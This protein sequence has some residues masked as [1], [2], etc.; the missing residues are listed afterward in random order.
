[1][2]DINSQKS[3]KL[4]VECA[5]FLFISVFVV[6]RA[7]QDL[8]LPLQFSLDPPNEEALEK[9]RK[10]ITTGFMDHVAR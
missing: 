10:V 7:F 8:S 4:I 1:M 5:Y 2:R 3:E 9:I 6:N